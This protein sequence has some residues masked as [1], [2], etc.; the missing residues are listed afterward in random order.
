[1]NARHEDGHS[2]LPL[3]LGHLIDTQIRALITTNNKD[4]N[5]GRTWVSE[6]QS[7]VL[8]SLLTS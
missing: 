5:N 1:M 6:I 7:Q 2:K 4:C 3:G 8:D